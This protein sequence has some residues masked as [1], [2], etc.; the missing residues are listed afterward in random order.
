[1]LFPSKGTPPAFVS[2]R[3]GGSTEQCPGEGENYLG[4]PGADPPGGRGE[5]FSSGCF[6]SGRPA[7]LHQNVEDCPPRT[8]GAHG[9]LQYQI[10]LI[11]TVMC[12]NWI[13]IFRRMGDSQRKPISG[14]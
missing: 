13:I 3:L 5:Y 10:K 2:P 14:Y 11:L 7:G 12:I 6:P 1:M 9:V 4:A 8:R